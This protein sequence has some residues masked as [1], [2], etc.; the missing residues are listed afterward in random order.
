MRTMIT[1]TTT[2]MTTRTIDRDFVPSWS[3]WSSRCSMRT[4]ATIRRRAEREALP[5]GDPPY[6]GR[7]RHL[8]R[9]SARS[10]GVLEADRVDGARRGRREQTGL[11]FSIP[12][13][14]RAFTVLERGRTLTTAEA[15]AMR[16]GSFIRVLA[17][18]QVSA[19]LEGDDK[20]L[21]RWV[22][23]TAELRP[24]RA[25]SSVRRRAGWRRGSC[26]QRCTSR[27]WRSSGSSSSATR[28]RARRT[29]TPDDLPRST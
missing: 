25:C 16:E 19:D 10:K 6:E 9:P 14:V 7:S 8:G 11:A 17:G 23:P 26:P 20:I 29:S 4:R 5:R 12:K 2:R 13:A 18:M 28:R 3:I 24:R 22:P 21:I 1:I 15:L 27:C